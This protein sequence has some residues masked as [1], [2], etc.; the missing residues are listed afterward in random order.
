MSVTREISEDG[1][2]GPGELVWARVMNPF[3]NRSSTGKPRPVVLVERT[4]GHWRTMGL[5][6]N[7]THRDGSPRH[8]VPN[9]KPVGLPGPG[10]IWGD[11]LTNVSVIDVEDHIGWADDALVEAVIDLAGLYGRFASGLRDSARRHH[12]STTALP[13]V[14][15]PA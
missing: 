5:T 7:P 10:F 13:D 15:A 3:E 4:G 2:P 8:R 14:G 12:A 1:A 11:R 9:W 6:T